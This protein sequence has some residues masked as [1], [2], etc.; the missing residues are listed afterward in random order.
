M[1]R[2]QNDDISILFEVLKQCS[3]KERP[4]N[5]VYGTTQTVNNN[6]ALMVNEYVQNNKM[7]NFKNGTKIDMGTARAIMIEGCKAEKCIGMDL[8]KAIGASEAHYKDVTC[9][10]A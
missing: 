5:S 2:Y 8:D 1:P 6:F 3:K 7:P 10:L 4:F 9:S